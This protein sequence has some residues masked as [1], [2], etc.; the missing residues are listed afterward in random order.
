[1]MQV[2]DIKKNIT[3]RLE[4]SPFKIR[5]SILYGSFVRGTLTPDSDID[6]LFVSDEVNLGKH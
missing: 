3:S 5:A 4:S 1:M 6:I 2:R